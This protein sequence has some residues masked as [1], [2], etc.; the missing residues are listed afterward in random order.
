MGFVTPALLAGAALIAIPI[1]LHLIMRRKVKQLKFPALRFVQQRRTLNQHRLRLRHLILLALRCAIIALLAFALARPMLR[2]SGAAGNLDAPVATALVFDNSLRMQYEHENATRLQKAKELAKWLIGQLPADEPITVVDRAGRQRGPDID[3]DAAE[4]RVERLELA[5]AVRPMEDALRDA[6]KWIEEKRNYR[7]EIYVF[8]DLT[9]DAW[10]QDTLAEFR[11]Q[12]DSLPG[13]NVYLIDVGVLTPRNVGLGALRLSSD[14]TTS[15]DV[16]QMNT[17]LTSTGQTN[18]E[19]ELAVELFVA[20]KAGTPEKRGQQVVKPNSGQPTPVEFSLSGL[21]QGTHQGYVRIAGSD[22]LVCDNVRYF[23]LDIQASSKVLLVGNSAADTLFLREALAPTAATGTTPSRFACQEG[24]YDQIEKLRLADFTTVCL[25]DPPAL[26]PAVWKKLADYAD[27][28]GG[29]GIFLGRQ[30]RR[31]DFN[32]ADPQQLLPTRLKWQSREATYL[33]P[34]AVEHPA[35]R[36]LKELTD[37]AAWSEFPVLKYWDLEAGAEPANVVASYANGK[38][39]LVERRLGAGRVLMLTTSI[40]DPASDD[41]WSL[42]PTA[43]DPWPFIALTNGIVSSITW[44]V[45][46]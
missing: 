26:P 7:G 30:A 29:V 32:L 35:L 21:K 8:T 14:Q 22:P 36:E 12:L 41:P 10:P 11:K 5:S 24:L 37:S 43:P 23:T 25:L 2:S 40:S 6:A 19:K 3:H 33:R 28:G 15:G 34:V 44:L 46:W 4:L 20:E 16:M 45:R 13:S 38:P 1:A 18:G 31:D 27:A 17:D 9:A 42:L 39:A